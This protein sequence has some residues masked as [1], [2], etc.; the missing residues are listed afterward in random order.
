MTL[1]RT[2]LLINVMFQTLSGN[3]DTADVHLKGLLS[4]VE[5][6]GGIRS[7]KHNFIV[8]RAVTWW[9]HVLNHL[10]TFTANSNQGRSKSSSILRTRTAVTPNT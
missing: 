7:L 6:Q 10:S 4:L 2:H 5:A 1:F 9:V 8:E 3:F